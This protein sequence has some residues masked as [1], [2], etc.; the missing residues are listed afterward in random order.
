MKNLLMNEA[1]VNRT[2]NHQ[3]GESGIYETYFTNISQA[4]AECI[5]S[6]GRC[7]GKIYVDSPEKKAM[8]IGWVFRKREKYE[9]CNEYFVKET[10]CS[11]HAKQDDVK[12]I[13]HYFDLASMKSRGAK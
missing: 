1:W 7:V 11:F 12:R 3:L 9:D 5:K 8:H 10:W 6:Y 4:Y 2:E 13:S